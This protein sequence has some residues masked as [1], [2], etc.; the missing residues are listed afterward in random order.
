MKLQGGINNIE[1]GRV[2]SMRAMQIQAHLLALANDNIAGFDKVGYQRKEAVVSSF[3]E[4]L[5]VQGVSTT[6]DDKTGR[7]AVSDNPL[8]IAIAQKGYFQVQTKNGVKLTRDGRFKLNIEGELLNLENQKVLSNCGTPI[9]LNFMPKE[10]KDIVVDEK[11]HISVLN[12]K[13]NKF[14]KVAT[15]GVVD[16]NGQG[17]M[18]P[19]LRQYYNEYSNVSLQNE[20]IYL[21]PV[22]KTFDANRQMFI[23]SNSTLQKA[24]GQ[25]AQ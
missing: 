3:S 20:F 13:T 11:G 4:Y 24:I 15:L 8:D 18:N 17:I 1:D 5:G 22:V 6:T 25:L 2:T 7:I 21:M 10:L 14:D 19:E 16:T 9:K 23:I 12:H